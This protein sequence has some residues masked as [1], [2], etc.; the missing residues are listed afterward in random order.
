MPM[1]P[2][3][4]GNVTRD[5][6]IE[7]AR[8]L[9][10][11]VRAEAERAEKAARIP[12]HVYRALVER[13]F[14][15]T[16]LPKR[17]GGYE[18]EPAVA[19]RIVLELAAGCGSTGWV[20]SCAMSHQWMVAQFPLPCHDEVWAE[21]PDQMVVTS[22][23]P[24]GTCERADG[25]FRLTGTWQYASGCDYADYALLGARLPPQGGA[26]NPVPGF[27]VVPMSDCAM[28]DDW[29]T[30]GLAATGSHAV[31][32][33]DVFVPDHRA[34]PIPV[35][36]SSD[37]PGQAAFETELGAYPVFSVGSHGL[38][39]TAVGCL[40]GALGEFAAM[41]KQWRAGALGP[42]MGA[43]VA[44]FQSVQMRVGHAGAALK[45]AKALLFRQMEDS[46]RAL[47]DRGEALDVGARIDNRIAQGYAIQLAIQG[48]DQLWGAA[49]G[50]GIR[51]QG[52]RPARL[53]RCPRGLAPR[54][55][56]LGRGVGHVRPAP[57]GTGAGRAILTLDCLIRPFL[58]TNHGENRV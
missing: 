34:I 23:A 18:F 17:Y 32:L 48:L 36:A 31:A 2:P 58:I 40:Q 35:F 27:V 11:I 19:A 38:A 56:Q 54:V 28:V 30:M 29:D 5:G 13:G 9:A 42:T 12:E 20:A 33:D 4:D 46:R 47:Y 1:D 44:D 39:A 37:A 53:A 16:L 6:L 21:G 15:R 26:D 3:R 14:F 45:A 50:T 49:G 24:T 57:S 25:G 43:Q 52:S 41:L 10:P 55:L 7:A 51:Q 8:E 22:F